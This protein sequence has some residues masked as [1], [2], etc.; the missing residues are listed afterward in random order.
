[1][2]G[3]GDLPGGTFFSSAQ[4]VSADGLVVVGASTGTSTEDAFRWTQAGGMVALGFLPGDNRSIATATSADGAVVVGSSRN[5]NGLWQSFRWTS[6][7]GMFGIGVDTQAHDVSGD[8]MTIVGRA[9]TVPGN[10]A[11]LWTNALGLVDL[12]MHLIGLGVTGL[13]GW[14]LR[15]ALAVS[16]D[17]NAIVGF[18]TN[19]AG[20]TEAWIAYLSPPAAGTI[21]S[22]Y[23]GPATPNSSGQPAILLAT[24]SDFALDFDVTLT[25][26]Q[27][28]PGQFGYFLAGR[29]QGFFNP[30]GS[31][32]FICLSGNVGRYNRSADIIQGPTG[33]LVLDLGAIPVNPPAAVQAGETWNFQCWFRDNNPALTNNFTDGLEIL[34]Q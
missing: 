17:G 14:Q 15:E 32:G 33:S 8:G 13:T 11:Y 21:G 16:Q 34:F 6:A 26:T 3:L 23:C 5:P 18:G 9:F 1:M 4:G 7:T 30:P 2:V 22:S 19:P 10:E 28:P 12:R 25:A 24:G 20:Q 27:L 31:Q 29:N